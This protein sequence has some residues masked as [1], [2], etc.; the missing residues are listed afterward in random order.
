MILMLLCPPIDLYIMLVCN[1]LQNQWL[2]GIFWLLS[3]FG[4]LISYLKSTTLGGKL[5]S[6]RSFQ[7]ISQWQENFLFCAKKSHVGLGM[8]LALSRH[9]ATNQGIDHNCFPS[10]D[11]Q[12]GGIGC[13]QCFLDD[14][15]SK[16]GQCCP[17]TCMNVSICEW[18]C[19]FELY[20]CLSIFLDNH[21]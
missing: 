19:H 20:Q 4:Y 8:S 12:M 3:P 5:P 16:R 17:Q 15:K 18:K 9:D 10:W 2:E 6:Y 11:E 14:R 1:E 21:C 7:K 13:L